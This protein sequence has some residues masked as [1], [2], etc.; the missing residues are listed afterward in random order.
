MRNNH[1]EILDAHNCDG[2]TSCYSICPKNAIDMKP[3][4]FGFLYP[5]VNSDKCIDCGLCMKVCPL[6]NKKDEK[7]KQ[8]PLCFA[9]RHKKDKEVLK[10][11][12]G[13]IFKAI[14]DYVLK[15][16]GVVYGAAFDKTWYVRHI[17][18]DNTM[19]LDALRGSKYVQSDVRGIFPKIYSDLQAGLFVCFSG[20]PCQCAGLQSY[21]KIRKT[22]ITHLLCI[23]IVCHG[24]PSPFLWKEYVSW[25]QKR[26][27][28]EI[29]SINMRDKTIVGWNGHEE[30]FCF[31]H[32]R[33]IY[34]HSF[35]VI[36]HTEL[37]TRK[38]CYR[39]NFANLSR[40]S[41]LTLA[42]FWNWNIITPDLN[43][44]NKGVSQ[45][46]VNTAKGE[47][48]LEAIAK[49]ICCIATNL[50]ISKQYN[51]EHSTPEPKGRDDAEKFYT[52]NG[53]K[54]FMRKYGDWNIY[55]FLLM[56]YRRWKHIY[57]NYK[58]K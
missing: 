51:M 33:K 35:R 53:F 40:P 4:A 20:T 58:Q 17:R 29:T 25:I 37:I 39:C 31:S 50:Q 21:L 56:Q 44:D 49:D 26:N 3:D 8:L 32:K 28:D 19:E 13:G 15:N 41:D 5:Q 43:R 9:A 16:K 6:I 34:R 30:S 45:I 55:K 36:Y 22:D 48:L 24:V 42:D 14:G 54:S 38:S 57:R 1:I 23:D 12:S 2:C 52:R 11:R 10:S 27:K 18:V 7:N 47:K 46:L